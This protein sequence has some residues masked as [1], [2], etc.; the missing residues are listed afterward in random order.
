VRGFSHHG[1]TSLSESPELATVRVIRL[2]WP[3]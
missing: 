1:F 3:D 2:G